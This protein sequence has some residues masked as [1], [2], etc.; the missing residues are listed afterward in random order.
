MYRD[1][2]DVLEQGGDRLDLIMIPKVGTAADVYAV[3]MLV[4]QVRTRWAAR[5]ASASS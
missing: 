3:D 2:V 5:S 4:T 1:V